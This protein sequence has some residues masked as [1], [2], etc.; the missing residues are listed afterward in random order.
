MG[1]QI[2]QSL[3]E[4]AL[5]LIEGASQLMDVYGYWPSFHDAKVETV[6]IERQGPT[7]TIHFVTN[8]LVDKDGVQ[9]RDKLAQVTIRW[10]GVKDLSFKG[11]DWEENNWI[12]GLDVR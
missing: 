8:D 12:D 1:E 9:E 5:T 10:H 11:L 7:V 2:S 4:R 3:E 6:V